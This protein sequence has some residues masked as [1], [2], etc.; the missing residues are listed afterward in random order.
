MG[1]VG[2]FGVF[3]GTDFFVKFSQ[4]YLD[5]S[6]E[7]PTFAIRIRKTLVEKVGKVR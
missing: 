7:C 1:S 2:G 3:E 5:N 4:K 6:S